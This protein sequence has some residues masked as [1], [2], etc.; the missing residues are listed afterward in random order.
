MG[1]TSIISIE[2]LGGYGGYGT[3]QRQ[4][5]RR[6]KIWHG[7]ERGQG[8]MI[9]SEGMERQGG[10][11]RYGTSPWNIMGTVEITWRPIDGYFKMM[12]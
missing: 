1:E 8:I 10:R 6:V 12:S 7:M 5:H 2:I 4:R 3:Y 11:L 9:R